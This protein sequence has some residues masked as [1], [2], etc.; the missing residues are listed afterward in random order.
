MVALATAVA[1]T[2]TACSDDDGNNIEQPSY[3]ANFDDVV[4]GG[5]SV[6]SITSGSS[7]TSHGYTFHYTYNAQ[8]Q[9]WSG[10]T[11][12][13]KKDTSFKDY[14]TDKNS[15]V[16]HGF[17]GNF[18]VYYPTWGTPSTIDMPGNTPITVRGFYGAVNTYVQ[19]SILNGDGYSKKFTQGSW[20][21][22]DCIGIKADGTQDT[23]SYYLAEYL[24][25]QLNYVRDWTWFDLTPLGD[26]K[27]VYFA[28][29]G[30]DK[31]AYGLNTPTYLLL[32]EFNGLY[33]N[34]HAV[35]TRVTRK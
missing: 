23:V 2:F 21:R 33:D 28:F 17:N 3:D 13:G 31:G 30:S 8:Y 32:D 18:A 10:F 25:K 15:C 19:N 27:Q 35:A 24:G 1:F 5:D 16:G 11:V 26:V 14:T 20:L 9:S 4:L 12:S 6:L 7:F 22:L 34:K 29:D